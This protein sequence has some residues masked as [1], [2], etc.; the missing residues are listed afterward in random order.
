MTRTGGCPCRAVRYTIDGPVRDVIVCHCDACCEA[1]GG[2]WSASAVRREHFTL[3][4]P[5][6]LVW[7]KAAVS[8]HDAS[9]AWCRACGFCLLWDAPARETVSFAADSL[10]DSSDLVVARHIW[11]P[12]GVEVPPATPV[13]WHET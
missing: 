13:E 7:E 2:P 11:V 10:D 12:A 6:V 3:H 8:E 4:D 9:R 1:S 5:D